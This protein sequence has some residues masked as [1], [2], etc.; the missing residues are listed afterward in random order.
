MVLY[1]ELKCFS[2][3]LQIGRKSDRKKSS[4]LIANGAMSRKAATMHSSSGRAK[5]E[6]VQKTVLQKT[7]DYSSEEGEGVAYPVYKRA[8]DW[9]KC[10]LLHGLFIKCAFW[11]CFCLYFNKH[12]RHIILVG[13]N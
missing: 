8:G 6:K 12:E 9:W 2:L 4:R 11:E 10:V 5:E 1:K 13:G 3:Q 7:S